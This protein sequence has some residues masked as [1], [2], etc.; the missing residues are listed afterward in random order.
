M[1]MES[2]SK[3]QFQML[4]G[5][6]EIWNIQMQLLCIHNKIDITI[7]HRK[8]NLSLPNLL[9]ANNKYNIFLHNVREHDVAIFPHED[10]H[11]MVVFWL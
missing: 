5:W 10:E 3:N 7:A 1:Y 9:S 2:F 8:L 11:D 4:F 6:L